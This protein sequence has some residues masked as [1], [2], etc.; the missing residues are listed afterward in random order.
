M[1]SKS[2]SIIY[3]LLLALG[4][5]PVFQYLQADTV[6]LFIYATSVCFLWCFSVSDIKTRT[7]SAI[8][9]NIGSFL[10]TFLSKKVQDTH[11]AF[12]GDVLI[13]GY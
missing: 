7:I 11:V 3:I 1:K 9:V 8:M 13:L 2:N 12:L 5:F 4:I 10:T 6:N